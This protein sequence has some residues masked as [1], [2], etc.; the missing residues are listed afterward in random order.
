MYDVGWAWW[1]LMS[2]GMVAFWVLA[3]YGVVWLTRRVN[4]ADRA[5][6]APPGPTESPQQ[7]VKRRLAGGEI[8]VDE[9]DT[10]RAVID[11]PSPPA[12]AEPPVR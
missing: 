8:S 6:A 9:Y 10:L 2:V 7:V 4:S 5:S 1:L 11:D 3:I 12:P